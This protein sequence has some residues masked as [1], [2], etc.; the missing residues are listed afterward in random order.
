MIGIPKDRRPAADSKSELI[1]GRGK[2]TNLEKWRGAGPGM[3]EDFTS[4]EKGR[5]GRGRLGKGKRKEIERWGMVLRS[6]G[7]K[8]QVAQILIK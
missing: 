4:R 2:V 6:P 3:G 1:R 7:G 5:P 8:D